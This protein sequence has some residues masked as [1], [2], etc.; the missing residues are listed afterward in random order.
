MP[1]ITA[2][3]PAVR[4]KGLND[5]RCWHVGYQLCD[6]TAEVTVYARTKLKHALRQWISFVCAA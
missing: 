6:L 1:V 2:I 3:R 5:L 4:S